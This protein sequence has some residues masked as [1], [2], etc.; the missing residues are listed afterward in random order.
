MQETLDTTVGTEKRPTFLTVLCILTF[1]GSGL[2]ILGGLMGLI[3]SPILGYFA[4]QGT[5]LVQIIG[6]LAS[7]LCLF[8]AFK[9]WNL[10]KQGF[11]FYVIGSVL[12]IA[13]SIIGALAIKSTV[14]AS[15]NSIEG[16]DPEFDAVFNDAASNLVSSAAWTGVIVGIIINIIFILMYNANRKYLIK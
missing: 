7:A 14:A 3:G 11:M 9:M 8:G 12:S 2:G 13:G 15:L 1:I 10:Y 16:S 5:I 4:P 6:L